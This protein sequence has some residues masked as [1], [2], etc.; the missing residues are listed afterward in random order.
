M[1]LRDHFRPPISKRSSWE[2]FHGL[3]PA[4]KVQGLVGALPAN[5]VAE[6]RVHLGTF[7]EIDGATFDDDAPVRRD[8]NSGPAANGGAAAATC[9]PPTP[10]LTLDI[11]LPEQSECRTAAVLGPR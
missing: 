1:P 7:F 9:A 5:Y 2:G 4:T 3:W 8:T 6:P 11:D 10:T